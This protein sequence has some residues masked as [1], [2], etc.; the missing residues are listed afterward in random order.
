[1]NEIRSRGIEIEIVDIGGGLGINYDE[2]HPPDP[3]EWA[4]MIVPVVKEAGCRLI[5]EPGRSIVGNAGVL[6]TRVIYTKQNGD[7]TFVVVDAA[8]NDIMRPTLYGS[9]H[10]IVPVTQRMGERRIVDI[11]GPICESGDFLARDREIE[12]PDKGDILA[13][14]SAGAYGMTM[15]SNYN[16]RPR[17][18]EVMVFKNDVDLIGRR[19]TYEDLVLREV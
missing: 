4:S 12:M 15:S 18:A 1:M 7:K 10:A 3:G 6:L 17:A 8:M 14:M 13:V 19:E 9:H 2:E 11:V 16:S 5:L